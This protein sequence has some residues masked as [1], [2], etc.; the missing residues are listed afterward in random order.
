AGDVTAQERTFLVHAGDHVGASPPESALFQDEPS[1]AFFNLLG[2]RHC[3]YADRMHPRCNLV[4]TP[5]NHEFDEGQVEM[6]RLIRGGTHRSGPFVE[7][8]YRGARFPYISA[9]VVDTG[10]GLPI[11]PPFVIKEVAG[12]RLAF[13][14]AVLKETPAVVPPTGVAGL[15]FLDEATSI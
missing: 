2:N 14:G 5:G 13:I 10:T 7:D 15:R 4:G 1:I 3:S 9:N 12:I 6:L 11:L 8:P